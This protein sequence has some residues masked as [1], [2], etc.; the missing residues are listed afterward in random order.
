MPATILVAD[1]DACL[2]RLLE[3]LLLAGGYL[4]LCAVD[5]AAALAVAEREHP[6]LILSDV[7]MPQLSGVELARELRALED[8]SA[9]P[10]LLMSAAAPDPLP[11]GT[12]F[13][14]KPFAPDRLLRTVA[15]LLP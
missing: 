8:D 11:E 1:D 14:A 2:L 12:A 15:A 5:G 13:I 10:I 3:A 9:P 4:V 6:D 7:M